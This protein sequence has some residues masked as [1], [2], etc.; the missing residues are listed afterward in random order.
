MNTSDWIA[1]AACVAAFLALI[2]A[3]TPMLR[4]RKSH[5]KMDST[6]ASTSPSKSADPSEP[7]KLNAFGKALVLTSM[8]L[9]I[10]VIEIVLFSAIAEAFGVAVDVKTMPTNWLIVFYALFFI[11]G[12]CLFWAAAHLFNLFE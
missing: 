7:A 11:P 6:Q 8:A 1:L 5:G 12:V 9:V 3:F 4:G 2:P 10:G